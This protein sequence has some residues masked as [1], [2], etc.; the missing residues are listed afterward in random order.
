MDG[1]DGFCLAD[2]I[3]SAI[4]GSGASYLVS[5]KQITISGPCHARYILV[6][7][8]IIEISCLVAVLV[9]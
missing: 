6:A 4:T 8:A 5:A 9:H 7:A 3:A 2:P 1:P